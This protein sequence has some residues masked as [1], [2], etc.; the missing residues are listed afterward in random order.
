MCYNWGDIKE[1]KYLHMFISCTHKHNISI[2]ERC[3]LTLIY[4]KFIS[5][6][7]CLFECGENEIAVST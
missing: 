5:E 3:V 2:E 7:V 1:I 6:C 4:V